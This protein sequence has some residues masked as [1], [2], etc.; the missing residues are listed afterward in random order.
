MIEGNRQKKFSKLIQKELSH[1][2]QFDCKVPGNY[3][4][5]LSAIRS[6]R[7][8]GICRVYIT[9]YPSQVRAKSIEFLNIETHNIRRSLAKR[10]GKY[11]KQIPILE[12]FEDDTLDYVEKMDSIF[13]DLNENEKGINPS[14]E[15]HDM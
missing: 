3:M 11:V 4:V 5:T 15:P 13:D 10:I 12:F 8:L 14:P 6:T 9:V 7:D 2:L 1:V